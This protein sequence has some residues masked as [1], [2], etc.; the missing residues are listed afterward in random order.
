MHRSMNR[1]TSAYG[2]AAFTRSAT[3]NDEWQPRQG[4]I[5]PQSITGASASQ[6]PPRTTA[7]TVRSRW[8]PDIRSQQLVTAATVGEDD[9]PVFASSPHVVRARPKSSSG[10]APGLT[11]TID[12]SLSRLSLGKTSGATS[13]DQKAGSVPYRVVG[14]SGL[15]IQP[16]IDA[17]APTEPRGYVRAS[18]DRRVAFTTHPAPPP[19]PP[20]AKKKGDAESLLNP[21]QHVSMYVF[22]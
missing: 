4:T 17:G 20:P 6:E 7:R 2:G 19:S 13:T 10:M 14:S 1:A 18:N 15:R 22:S 12:T 9:A 5:Q 11:E 8:T 21:A 16:V 3:H